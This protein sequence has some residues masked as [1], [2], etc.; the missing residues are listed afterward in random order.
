MFLVSLLSLYSKD[1]DKQTD[2][3]KGAACGFITMINV[4]ARLASR[5]RPREKTE[6][7]MKEIGIL[8]SYLYLK[9]SGIY[10]EVLAQLE[11]ESPAPPRT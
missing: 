5:A 8:F 9:A 2:G 10:D 7:K 3:T 1:L 4:P 6:V 11:A